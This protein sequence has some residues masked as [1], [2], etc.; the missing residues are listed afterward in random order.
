[1]ATSWNYFWGES[2]HDYVQ[3]RT[4]TNDLTEA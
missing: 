4:I 2:W 1:M 3:R